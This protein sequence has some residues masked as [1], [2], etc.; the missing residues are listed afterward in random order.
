LGWESDRFTYRAGPVPPG[1]N[2]TGPVPTGFANPGFKHSGEGADARS[3]KSE[4]SNS[5]LQHR[6]G[7]GAVF[8]LPPL[9]P[10]VGV[11]GEVGVRLRTRRAASPSGDRSSPVAPL[12]RASSTFL[13]SQA[14]DLALPPA[15][16]RA[17]SPLLTPQVGRRRCSGWWAASCSCVPPLA[18]ACSWTEE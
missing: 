13:P 4:E 3:G 14:F 16:S 6:T 18:V 7:G 2:R 17:S 1:T 8:F 11:T 10:V 5:Y 9:R 12:S 15:F